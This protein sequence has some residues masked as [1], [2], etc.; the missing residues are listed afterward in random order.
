MHTGHYNI[1]RMYVYVCMYP[2]SMVC[3]ASEMD[4]LGYRVTSDVF[5]L[6]FSYCLSTHLTVHQ[7]KLCTCFI[8]T[9]ENV[10]ILYC[11]STLYASF[12]YKHV[13][14]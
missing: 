2:Y 6:L 1:L 14:L 13:Q 3:C 7:S 11:R 10:W 12:Y 9:A 8:K 5:M 4:T